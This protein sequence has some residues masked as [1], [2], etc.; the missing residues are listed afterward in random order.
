MKHTPESQQK[1]RDQ[2]C[3]ALES[4]EYEQGNAVLNHNGKL[5]CLGV[6]CEEA[7]TAGIA[8]RTRELSSHSPVSPLYPRV[9]YETET[10]SLPV[11]VREWLGLTHQEGIV[12]VDAL[13]ADPDLP[14]IEPSKAATVYLSNLNDKYR[15][16][17][18]QIAKVVR[19]GYVASE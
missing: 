4:G 11:K 13:N 2:W 7:R 12:D 3:H 10:V 18:E 9:M 19:R 16:T 14:E 8:L 5:C 17:F 15:F 6:A 1:A